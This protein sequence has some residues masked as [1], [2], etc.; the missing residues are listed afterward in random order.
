LKVNSNVNQTVDLID[1]T[2]EYINN[3]ELFNTVDS[4]KLKVTNQSLQIDTLLNTVNSQFEMINTLSEKLNSILNCLNQNNLCL[5]SKVLDSSEDSKSESDPWILQNVPNPFRDITEIK[6]HLPK[7]SK[8]A[9]IIVFDELGHIVHSFDNLETGTHVI[10][11]EAIKVTTRVYY[12]KFVVDNQVI[13]TRKMQL[14]N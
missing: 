1:T 11:F 10:S 14:Y 12:Y 13:A 6:Y 7:Y 9:S 4:L 8:V 3:K 5:Q 2:F